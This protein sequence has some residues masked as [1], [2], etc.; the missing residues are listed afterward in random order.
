MS[1]GGD[2]HDPDIAGFNFVGV[3]SRQSDNSV[4][5]AQIV[6]QG[7]VGLQH[8]HLYV[9]VLHLPD[10]HAFHP[11]KNKHVGSAPL[12]RKVKLLYSVPGLRLKRLLQDK[13]ARHIHKAVVLFVLERVLQG[14]VG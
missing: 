11:L 14:A 5:T 10:K 2:A 13:A 6:G 9:A 3:V 7:L 1:G 12:L 4:L 8:C